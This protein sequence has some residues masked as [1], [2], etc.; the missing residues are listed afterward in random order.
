MT[1]HDLFDLSFLGRKSSVAI[2]FGST[3]LTFGE[4]DSRT[5]ALGRDLLNRGLKAG[6]RLCVYMGNSLE[7]VELFLACIKTG[8][9]FVPI[10]ILYR[11][12]ETEHI[13]HDAEPRAVVT[14]GSFPSVCPPGIAL[15]E[16]SQLAK[17]DA[18]R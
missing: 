14:A 2:E 17:G 6:D 13:L 5:N 1:L 3:E 12:R 8:I 11:Q 16:V 15:W 4:L 18:R 9:I 7:I 10:N